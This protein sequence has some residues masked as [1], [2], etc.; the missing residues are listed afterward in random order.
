MSHNRMQTVT[1]YLGFHIP[2]D[3]NVYS[4]HFMTFFKL[5]KLCFI[6]ISRYLS[7]PGLAAGAGGG[8]ARDCE[9]GLLAAH[10]QSGTY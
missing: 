9:A 3:E 2:L 5:D 1:S 8:W 10:L 4:L 7:V 6:Y